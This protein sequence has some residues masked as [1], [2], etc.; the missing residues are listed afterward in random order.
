MPALAL[1]E[2]ASPQRYSSAGWKNLETNTLR[3]A[4]GQP[5]QSGALSLQMPALHTGRVGSVQSASL[6]QDVVHRQPTTKP[7]QH[8]QLLPAGHRIPPQSC[9]VQRKPELPSFAPL[10]TCAGAQLQVGVASTQ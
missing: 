5:Q 10:S 8:K 6:L 1:S 9:H 4:Y 3:R 7:P 2:A